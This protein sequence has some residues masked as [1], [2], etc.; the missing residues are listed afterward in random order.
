MS[1]IWAIFGA[2]GI[3]D[4]WDYQL[5]ATAFPGLIQRKIIVLHD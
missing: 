2:F 1:K 5:V 4:L 3:K